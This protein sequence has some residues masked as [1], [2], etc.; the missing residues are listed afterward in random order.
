[1]LKNH[2]KSELFRKILEKNKNPLE[3]VLVESDNFCIAKRLQE[4]DPGYVILLNLK[5]QKFEVH[6][7]FQSDTYCLTLPYETLDA[8]TEDYVRKTS[9]ARIDEIF[10]ELDRDNA[11]R[12]K[13]I[14]SALFDNALEAIYDRS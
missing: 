3:F 8:R 14:S 9:V 4:I 2:E 10:K 13:D 7:V 6:N 12:E 5:T 1:M 11:K